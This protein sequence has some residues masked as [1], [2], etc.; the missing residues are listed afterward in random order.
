MKI[1]GPTLTFS[2]IFGIL[3][4]S[5]IV[6]GLTFYATILITITGGE[7]PVP[8]LHGLPVAASTELAGKSGLHVEMVGERY[9]P[10]VPAGQVISQTPEAGAGIKA[11]RKVKVVVSLGTEILKV[12]DLSGETER[13][14][15]IEIDRLGLRLGEVSRVS[16][17]IPSDRVIN[18]DPS[19]DSEIFRGEKVNLLVSRGPR[20]PVYVMPDLFGQPLERVQSVLGARGFRLASTSF[21]RSPSRA[22]TVLRQFPLSGYPVTRRD[23]ITVVVSRGSGV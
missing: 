4:S 9:D 6:M 12:P 21:E 14:A 11:N 8:D 2:K 13:R 3:I 22:G 5:G 10:Q 23:A 1:S 19:P 17:A 15:V 18:Q 7:I 16:A 20:E